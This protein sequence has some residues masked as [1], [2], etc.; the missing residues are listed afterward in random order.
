MDDPDELVIPEPG[1]A[2]WTLLTADRQAAF[3]EI[4]D[5]LL[6]AANRPMEADEI[7]CGFCNRLI[8][9]G[10]PLDRQFSAFRVL[11]STDV[12]YV[13]VWQRGEGL[14]AVTIP[15][16]SDK[17]YA[18]LTSP[19]A[20]AHQLGSWI[21]FDPQT[22]PPERFGI[23]AELKEQGF[24]HYVCAPVRIL[25]LE[26]AV[27]FA[28]RSPAGFSDAD[29]LFLRALLPAL[30]ALNETRVLRRVLKEVT[31]IYVGEEPHKRI[32]SGDVHRGEVTG[33]RSAILFA[34]MRGFTSLTANMTAEET[35]AL[36]NDYFDCVV[37]AVEAEGGEVLK[38][39]GDG[40]LAIVRDDEGAAEA[41]KRAWV[42]ATKGHD[43]IETRNR[44]TATPFTAGI[45]L[46]YGE[47]AYGNVGSGMRLDYTIIGKD[48][49]LASRICGLCG[50]L[51]RPLLASGAFR[52]HLDGVRLVSDGAHRL[53]GFEE[54]IEVFRPTGG[55]TAKPPI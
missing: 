6:K 27:T 55:V 8:A 41:C 51:D 33:I 31:R 38:F 19:F 32:L 4:Q 43:A 47:V 39:M 42:A 21:G 20:H 22:L 49:N 28:T 50:S 23:V 40:V 12:S 35:T 25:N 45:A 34:D 14:T 11:H 24:R 44:A 29:I 2:P 7:V 18:Y 16:K 17:D 54:P 15:Y 9:A 26:D 36:L 1:A 5:F 13:E 53:K 3:L 46:H 52:R 37:P 48:V 30:T 10:L